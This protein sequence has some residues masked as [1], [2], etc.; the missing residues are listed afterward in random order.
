MRHVK[1]LSA[2]ATE[3]ARIALNLEDRTNK[4][5]DKGL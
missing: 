5:K 1:D 2:L 3:F 4:M